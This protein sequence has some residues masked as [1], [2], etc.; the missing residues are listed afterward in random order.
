MVGPVERGI[1]R[2]YSGTGTCKFG[3]NC[4]FR[5]VT[6]NGSPSSSNRTPE[7]EMS[8]SEQELRS[9]KQSLRPYRG[10]GT[11][12]MSILRACFQ[13]GLDLVNADLGVQQHTLQALSEENGLQRIQQL[14]ELSSVSTTAIQDG[15]FRKA[16]VPL[17]KIITHEDVTISA[18]M[19]EYLAKIVTYLYGPNGQRAT[20][21]FNVVTETLKKISDSDTSPTRG[22]CFILRSVNLDNACH[23]RDE[24]LRSRQRESTTACWYVT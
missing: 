13:N 4:K 5:H 1:C 15:L 24:W 8:L 9:W 22:G 19:E 12:D 17:F 2:Y 10:S 6:P 7:P 3:A 20:K 11:A 18:V 16:I 21:L 14:V 23:H